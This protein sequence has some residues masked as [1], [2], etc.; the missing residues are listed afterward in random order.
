MAPASFTIPGYELIRELGSGGMANVFLA[1][2]RSLDRRVAIKV[3]RRNIDELDK[4]ERRFLM[5]GRTMAKLPHRN[6]VAVYDIVKTDELT[7]IAMEFLEGGTLSVKMKEGLSL[8][9]AISVVVQIAQALQFAHDHGIVHRDLKPANIMFRDAYTPVLT[10]FGIAKQ[11]DATATRLTQTG[12]LVGT[13]TYMSPEQINALEVDGRS[14]MYSLGVLFYEL[15]T[16]N[17]PFTGDTPISVLMAHLTT[18]APALPE[19]FSDFQPVIDQLLAKNRDDRFANLRDFTR[20]LKS[21]VVGNQK[22]WARLQADPSQSSS[23]QLRALGFSISGPASL[24]PVPPPPSTQQ[25]QRPRTPVGRTPAPPSNNAGKE[26]VPPPSRERPPAK[27]AGVPKTWLYAA[28]GAGALLIVL[29]VGLALWPDKPKEPPPTAELDPTTKILIESSLREVDR[30]IDEGKLTSPPGDNAF[31]YL[32]AIS[33]K[34]AQYEGTRKRVVKV[35]SLLKQ[36]ASEALAKEDFDS[37]QANLE[38][39]R[40]VDPSDA[41]VATIGKKITANRSLVESR[42]QQAELFAKV[43]KAE[44]EGR[45]FGSEGAFSLLQRAQADAPSDEAI[46]ERLAKLVAKSLE[47]PRESL[48]QGRLEEANTRL[49]ELETFLAN[50]AAFKALRVEF[51]KASQAASQRQRLESLLAKLDAEIKA[52]KLN[53]PAGDNAIE[54]LAQAQVM[55]PDTPEVVQRRDAVAARLLGLAD[56]SQ[57]AGQTDAALSALNLA[58]DV[59]PGLPAALQLKQGIE[60]NL[61]ARRLRINEGL[62]AAQRA[63]V[64]QQ[65]VGSGSTTAKAQFEAVLALDPENALAK[66]ALAELPRRILDAAKARAADGDTAAA[67]A[68]VSDARRVYPADG[69]L[70]QLATDLTRQI[71]EAKAREERNQ[72]YARLT[73]LIAARPLTAEASGKAAREISALLAQDARDVDA[74][75]AKKRLFDALSEM[76]GSAQSN[77]DIAQVTAAFAPVRQQFA[78]DPLAAQIATRLDESGKRIAEAEKARIAATIG[79]L[80]LNA[81]PWATVESVTDNNTGKAVPLP[82]DATTPLRLSLPAGVYSVS[83]RHPDVARATRQVAQV[84]EK[85]SVTVATAFSSITSRDYLKRAGW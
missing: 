27:P 47:Q 54:T 34:A 84:K 64:A 41:E 52:G 72:R 61:D 58:L 80:V 59:K 2:Q 43:D 10:D 79:E 60:K 35:A 73:E 1:V 83:F 30:F 82:A 76:L 50:E 3:M 75:S 9:E 68:L 13:P 17:P 11:Q 49:R 15:L 77:N 55:A 67:L 57:R 21:V 7:Y 39:A 40:V 24:D 14:D 44:S 38:M 22:L 29:A 4:F 5:E 8:A 28:I 69:P 81:Y 32:Q 51:D 48:S 33:E 71:A 6:I 46:R 18:A 42:R 26:T 23:E 12:M 85:T 36:R 31:E 37:A 74:G 66:T 20:A 25:V 56:S 63:I 53:E 45:V 78:S 70:G 62:A 19:A 16:G 65:F